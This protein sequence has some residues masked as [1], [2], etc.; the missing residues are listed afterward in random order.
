MI[1]RISG[2]FCLLVLAFGLLCPL[3]SYAS[4][5]DR[6]ILYVVCDTPGSHL[7]EMSRRQQP[8]LKDI[9]QTPVVITYQTGGDGSSC[10]SLLARSRPDGHIISSMILPLLIL[11][12]LLRKNVGYDPD[13]ILPLSIYQSIPIGLAVQPDHPAKSLDGFINLARQ[14][15][16]KI[17][18]G[19]DARYS[20]QY[21]ALYQFQKLAGIDLTTMVFAGPSKQMA[22]FRSRHV[23]AIM[24]RSTDLLA[25]G[26]E[27]RVL[28]IGTKER[29]DFFPSVPTFLEMGIEIFP[30]ID[31][32]VC[33][34]KGTPPDRIQALENAF[35]RIAQ[36]DIVSNEFRENGLIPLAIGSN[37]ALRQ[38]EQMKQ[39]F[40]K[41]VAE[42]DKLKGRPDEIS[43]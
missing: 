10:W 2:K 17:K 9:L 21:L 3:G 38:M 12:P 18:V 23:E 37:Q 5:K 11:N 22:G 15:P 31:L 20:T 16:R 14:Y 40:S 4:S 13:S 1:R 25:H 32:G 28:S 41:L 30:R 34:R 8:L 39:D 36:Q 26:K 19:V 7:D 27:L 33:V 29:A 42:I 6:P 24:A 35:L 43:R